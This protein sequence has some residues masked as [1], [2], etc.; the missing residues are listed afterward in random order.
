M[1]LLVRHSEDPMYIPGEDKINEPI[2]KEKKQ[3]IK[4]TYS[5]GDHIPEVYES[6]SHSVKKTLKSLHPS[7]AI[8]GVKLVTREVN[9][10][11]KRVSEL[12]N[13]LYR[14][15]APIKELIETEK[16]Y[17]ETL[18]ELINNY[19]IPLQKNGLITEKQ[20]KTIFWEILPI[21]HINC[22]F[23]HRFERYY[24]T[25]NSIDRTEEE[26]RFG[27]FCLWFSYVCDF[28]MIYENYIYNLPLA[29]KV[30][31]EE[32]LKNKAFNTFLNNNTQ[33]SER[34]YDISSLM[35]APQQRIPRYNLLFQDM[36]KR[37]P[38]VSNNIFIVQHIVDK[39]TRMTNK[40]NRLIGEREDMSRLRELLNNVEGLNDAAMG[41]F[42]I[43]GRLLEKSFNV[44]Y[45]SNTKTIVKR[46]C[47]LFNDSILFVRENGKK[48][49]CD[50]FLEYNCCELLDEI[51]VLRELN[52]S[53]DN[54]NYITRTKLNCKSKMAI[55][56]HGI[57]ISERIK[58]DRAIVFWLNSPAETAKVKY[59]L[60][61]TI[62]KYL[63]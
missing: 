51:S 7:R 17:I 8:S 13:T 40:I 14:R 38:L 48:K 61:Q 37:T 24:G 2:Q 63:P 12:T 22:I 60:V 29:Q 3:G 10:E 49:I 39:I 28:L 30:I 16:S 19:M 46:I 4:K 55:I 57:I 42:V 35:V 25:I 21:Y 43:Q 34:H 59:T 11:V 33:K 23:L 45:W 41:N 32:R 54:L 52:H 20:Y 27:K 18:A 50:I 31:K 58:K 26:D 5:V 1:N 47:Y 56:L 9:G 36:I 62:E 53:I 6:N 15:L 44:H